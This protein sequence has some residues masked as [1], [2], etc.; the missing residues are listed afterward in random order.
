VETMSDSLADTLFLVA[1]A[2]VIPGWLGLVIAPQSS[3]VHKYCTFAVCFVAVLYLVSILK[4]GPVEGA[5]FSSLEG[6]VN[7]FRRGDRLVANACWSHYLAFDLVVGVQI[8]KSGVEFGFPKWQ[9][10]PITLL[11][12]MYG[13]AGFLAF[14]L[15]KFAQGK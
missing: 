5:S 1:N 8:A 9:M 4:A 12:L 10:I 15:L 2:A 6:V 11:T 3:K 14:I 7:I 13:P